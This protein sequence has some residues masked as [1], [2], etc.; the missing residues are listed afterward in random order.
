M[1]A[2]KYNKRKKIA[3]YWKII[4]GMILG[5]LWG[6]ISIKYGLKDINIFWIKPFGTVF[7]NLLKLMAMPLV[8]SSIVIGVTSVNNATRLS[9]IGIKAVIIYFI[10]TLSAILVGLILV[11]II[12]PGNFFPLDMRDDIIGNDFETQKLSK[13]LLENN[14]SN[15]ISFIESIVP[16]NI[17]NALISNNNMLQVIFFT[18][19]FGISLVMIS[20]KDSKILIDIFNSINESSLKIIHIIMNFAPIGVFAILSSI[21]IESAGN[22]IGNAIK[23]LQGL[24]IYSLT[25]ILGL[26]LLMVIV[27][28]LFLKITDKNIS[29]INFFT[30]IS[31]AQ[32]LA[33]S[34]SSSIATLPIVMECCEKKLNVS[35]EISRFVLPL[36]ATINM[37]GTSLYQAIAIVFIGQIF[38]INLDL[39]QQLL[40]IFMVWIASIGTTGSPGSS[41]IMT[42]IVLN[43]LGIPSEGISIVLAVDRILDM[44]RTVANVAGDAMVAVI[45]DR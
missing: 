39:Y 5:I 26:T 32:L 3:L 34:S 6:I 45:I 33:F 21:M 42:M 25:I 17:F 23:L 11:N 9:K 27:Y 4:I 20:K 19:F 13:L 1:I 24:G 40:I 35:K 37:D 44:F 36:G 8:I 18:I 15:P 16:D 38:G 14:N 12:K 22:S 29:I 41:I 2:I 43:T 31:D 30:S 7:F 28:P 10:S